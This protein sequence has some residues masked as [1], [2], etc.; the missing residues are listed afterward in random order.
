M[1]LHTAIEIIK[2]HLTGALQAAIDQALKQC[3][4]ESGFSV[5]YFGIFQVPSFEGMKHTN[6]RRLVGCTNAIKEK[7]I[8]DRLALMNDSMAAGTQHLWSGFFINEP[9]RSFFMVDEKRK[10]LCSGPYP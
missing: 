3:T 2:P 8:R 9:E 1:G 10:V 6:E 5:P 4:S 7:C